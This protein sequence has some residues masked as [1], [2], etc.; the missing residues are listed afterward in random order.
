MALKKRCGIGYIDI[1]IYSFYKLQNQ[2]QNI[3]YLLFSY[4]K[5][6]EFDAFM[7]YY[8]DTYSKHRFML[9]H[10]SFFF[11]FS[12]LRLITFTNY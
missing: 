6:K 12:I 9:R 3:N 11:F 4:P 10:K 2:F 7:N 5:E 1:H 8:S